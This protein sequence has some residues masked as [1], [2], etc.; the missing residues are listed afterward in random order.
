MDKMNDK[1]L[2][3]MNNTIN[4]TQNEI[5]TI[6]SLIAQIQNDATVFLDNQ[7]KL[8]GLT[9]ISTSHGFI[10]FVLSQNKD[11]KTN[12]LVPMTMKQISAK[13]DKNKSTTTV[14]ID[15]LQKYEY[16]TRKKDEKDERFAYISLSSK[17]K[18]YIEKM[19]NISKELSEKFYKGFSEEEKK[20]VFSL[21]KKILSNFN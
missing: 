10:L 8:A 13:I 2:N 1:I 16:I 17:G 21:L 15:K 6:S 14:L 11:V 19:E 4:E 12:E 18:S 5:S 20:T 3:V 9:E 7:L